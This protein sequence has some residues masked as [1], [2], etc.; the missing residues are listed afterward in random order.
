MSGRQ[1]DAIGSIALGD[2]ARPAGHHG[3]R[4]RNEAARRGQ[5]GGR[6]TGRYGEVIAPVGRGIDC[7]VR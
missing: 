1:P 7:V 5:A 3:R 4:G 2:R 6:V